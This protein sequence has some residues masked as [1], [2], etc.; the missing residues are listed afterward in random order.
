MP[1]P[2]RYKAMEPLEDGMA[3]LDGKDL[4]ENDGK[5]EGNDDHLWTMQENDG[6]IWGNRWGI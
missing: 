2:P 1:F 6:E 4:M 5:M 3:C